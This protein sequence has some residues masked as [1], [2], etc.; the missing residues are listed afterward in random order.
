MHIIDEEEQLER[1][2]KFGGKKGVDVPKN[3]KEAGFLPWEFECLRLSS[4]PYPYFSSS[5]LSFLPPLFELN[6]LF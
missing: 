2:K 5:S 1:S 4:L 6:N 3:E